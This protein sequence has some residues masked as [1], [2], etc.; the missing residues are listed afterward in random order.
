MEGGRRGGR[1]IRAIDEDM[2]AN[3]GWSESDNE[4]EDEVVEDLSEVMLKELTS[5]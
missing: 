3:V 1:E 4:N 2:V 5:R